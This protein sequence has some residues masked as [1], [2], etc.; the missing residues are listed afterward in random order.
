M[1]FGAQSETIQNSI[2]GK[3]P[4]NPKAIQ[5]SIASSVEIPESGVISGLL[6]DRNFPKYSEIVPRPPSSI[7]L[8]KS[9][10]N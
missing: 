4:K 9:L 8:K 6:I 7:N 5:S 10:N 2:R 3:P 1:L